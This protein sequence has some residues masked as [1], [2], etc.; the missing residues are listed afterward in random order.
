MR[1]R[2]LSIIFYICA[3]LC[4]A[5]FG[6]IVGYGGI[7]TSY[8][9][10]W[11]FFAFIFAAMA[12]FMRRS[13][14]HADDMPEFLPTFIYSTFGL[15]MFIFFMIMNLV[16]SAARG[17]ANENVDYC[18]VM[19]ARVY[20]DGISRTLMYRLDKAFDV[21]QKNPQAVLVLAGGQEDGD[22]VPEAF[23]MYNYLSMKGIPSQS[24][25][26]EA[27]ATSTLGII[28]SASEVIRKD[29]GIRKTP[30]GPGDRVWKPDYVPKVGIITSDYHI[31]RSMTI[32][33]ENGIEDLTAIPSRSDQILF[34]H[35]CVRE[36]AAILKDFFMGNLTIDEQHMPEIPISRE[37]AH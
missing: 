12:F 1:N 28:R 15:G 9:P 22:A 24:M 10:V 31:F 32:A 4:L 30:K 27:R 8:C 35:N 33:E 37:K 16:I 20:S 5:Y 17:G 34:V 14:K 13:L 25:R 21:Y 6:V 19:G 36:G 7:S 26:V 23:A 29:T 18:V 2:T 11:L 3:A